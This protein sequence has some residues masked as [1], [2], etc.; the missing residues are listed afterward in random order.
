MLPL[1]MLRK[2]QPV[3][4]WSV[5]QQPLCGMIH[6]R[7]ENQHER[8]SYKRR[9]SKRFAPLVSVLLSVFRAKWSASGGLGQ[10][11]LSLWDWGELAGSL[12]HPWKGSGLWGRYTLLF[13]MENEVTRNRIQ[14]LVITPVV[15]QSHRYQTLGCRGN[16]GFPV[17]D[18]VIAEMMS[19]FARAWQESMSDCFKECRKA[20]NKGFTPLQGSQY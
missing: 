12:L 8:G 20:G 15:P 9:I 10:E 6:P 7:S 2:G 5:C 13:Q 16:S 18:A 14:M 17:W 3:K 1:N 11:C 19:F 4:C